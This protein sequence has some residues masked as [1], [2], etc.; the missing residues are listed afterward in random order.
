[1]TLTLKRLAPGYY[2]TD[3]K[4]YEVTFTP[5]AWHIGFGWYPPFW[6]WNVTGEV[7]NDNYETKRETVEALEDWIKKE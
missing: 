2:R 4:E 6:S 3:N 5:K 7:P 1:M